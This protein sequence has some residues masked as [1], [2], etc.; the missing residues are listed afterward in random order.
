M[1]I[2]TKYALKSD[3]SYNH[4]VIISKSINKLCQIEDINFLM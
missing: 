2:S 3:K 4:I 1:S